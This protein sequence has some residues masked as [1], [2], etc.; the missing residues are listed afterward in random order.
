MPMSPEKWVEHAQLIELFKDFICRIPI[1]S[2]DISSRELD[3]SYPQTYD[4]WNGYPQFI[5][6]SCVISSP[7]C[8]VLLAAKEGRAAQSEGTESRGLPLH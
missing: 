4:H 6:S 8:T 3:P 5:K 1:E 2:W 7:T